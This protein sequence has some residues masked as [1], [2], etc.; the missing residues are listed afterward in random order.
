VDAA[1]KKP[2]SDAVVQIV[3]RPSTKVQSDPAGMFQVHPHF[4]FHFACIPGPCSYLYIPQ[5]RPYSDDLIVTH[6]N[7]ASC[8][9]PAHR[10]SATHMTSVEPERVTTSDILL[11]RKPR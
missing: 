11:E 1:T 7:Y 3:D 9:S 6:P 2:I 5:G 8:E 4:N 10:L